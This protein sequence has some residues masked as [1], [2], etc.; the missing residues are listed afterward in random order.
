MKL[1]LAAQAA[2]GIG[3]VIKRRL[4]TDLIHAVMEASRRP[5]VRLRDAVASQTSDLARAAAQ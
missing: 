1:V 5:L 3:Y 2:G 4:R